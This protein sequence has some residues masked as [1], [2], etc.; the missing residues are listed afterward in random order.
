M[1]RVS[2]TIGAAV[3]VLSVASTALA[4]DCGS[5]LKTDLG[6]VV[7]TTDRLLSGAQRSQP[8]P[9]LGIELRYRRFL[10]E[11]RGEAAQD[12][13]VAIR[14]EQHRVLQLLGPDQL[15]TG[16]A[17]WTDRFRDTTGDIALTLHGVTP[18][19]TLQ[20]QMREVFAMPR[21][22][23]NPFYSRQ[24]PAVTAWADLHAA[25]RLPLREAGDAIGILIT[26]GIE[27]K[28]SACTGVAVGENLIL[29]NWH[30]GLVQA[31]TVDLPEMTW[32][33]EEVC[34]SVL[35]D[36]SWDE[37][38]HSND[39]RCVSVIE[40]SENLDY[41]LLEIQPLAGQPPVLP[42]RLAPERL[43]AQDQIH[44]IHHPEARIKS[45]STNC[46]L[47]TLAVPGWRDS[48]K[49]TEFAH[50]C[51]TEGGSSGAPILDSDFRVRGLHHLGFEIDLA[52]CAP[53][54]DRTN[55]A[56]WIKEIIDHLSGVGVKQGQNG[57]LVRTRN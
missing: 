2:A 40:Q 23:E 39:F 47:G 4:A 34:K 48:S 18:D 41:A 44:L 54:G 6:D 46:E 20:I 30:C 12:W 53:T 28:A 45:F 10:L 35:I 52:T 9:Y 49:L 31:K 27:R 33:Q 5:R 1:K 25:A 11:R 56:V 51:D 21:N 19:D 16:Q 42:L 55:K 13:R 57:T 50:R 26:R 14:D 38:N 32:N 24:N 37:D 17:V 22:L 29:T 15:R 8:E 43:T 36:F 3:A 7:E